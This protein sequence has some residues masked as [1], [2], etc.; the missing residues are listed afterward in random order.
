M[1]T[2]ASITFKDEHE[3]VTLYQHCDGY[4]SGVLENLRKAK[5]F[6]WELPR[7]EACEFA[8]AY[9]AANKTGPGDIYISSECDG[10]FEY[11]VIVEDG[12]LKVAWDGG[13]YTEV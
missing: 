6:A 12:I 8:A 1:S 10:R 4:P 5:D 11:T 2:R 7:F 3:E 13:E 9:I